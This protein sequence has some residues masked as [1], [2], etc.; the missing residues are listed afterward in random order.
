MNSNW[1]AAKKNKKNKEFFTKE[2]NFDGGFF[3]EHDLTLYKLIY[4]TANEK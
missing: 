3:D 1:D 4:K 2:F